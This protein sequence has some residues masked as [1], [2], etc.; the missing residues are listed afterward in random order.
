MPVE[1]LLRTPFATIQY[2]TDSKIVRHQTFPAIRGREYRDVL[3]LGVETLKKRA[4]EKWLADERKSSAMGEDD[5]LWAQRVWLPAALR[6]G[7]KYWAIVLP[8]KD[9]GRRALKRASEA[10]STAGITART[11]SDP[12]EA[13][14]WLESQGEAPP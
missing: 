3:T 12:T 5:E 2:D 7:W 10:L 13:L 11:F 6:S 4:A 8:E 14:E 1:T 9:A